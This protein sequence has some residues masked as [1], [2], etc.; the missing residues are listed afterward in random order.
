[1]QIN[2]LAE[3]ESSKILRM[4]DTLL[5]HHGLGRNDPEVAAL[6]ENTPPEQ[7]VHQIQQVIEN[8]KSRKVQPGT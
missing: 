2:L 7:M 8:G 3:Q 4:L 6:T 1:M 5:E